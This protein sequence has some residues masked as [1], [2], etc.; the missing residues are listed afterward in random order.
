MDMVWDQ[1]RG[2]KLG[3]KRAEAP[4]KIVPGDME[5]YRMLQAIMDGRQTCAEASRVWSK[6]SSRARGYR[7]LIDKCG[8]TLTKEGIGGG[9]V[10]GILSDS[11]MA[12]A[13]SKSPSAYDTLVTAIEELGDPALES[14]RK[15]I[16]T[17]ML[18]RDLMQSDDV[19]SRYPRE[20]VLE[21]FNDIA[22]LAPT[23]VESPIALR[24]L[25]RKHVETGQLAPE[26]VS[27]IIELEKGTKGLE[28]PDIP[29]VSKEVILG[30][31]GG[32][33]APEV[34]AGPLE[35]VENK[36]TTGLSQLLSAVPG[37]KAKK[38]DDK[39]AGGKSE[40]KPKKEKDKPEFRASVQTG[41]VGG[42]SPYTFWR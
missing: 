12:R 13:M 22:S 11:A 16:R 41:S 24:A 37:P 4:A 18:L 31:A 40:S 38:K 2:A 36:L 15:S 19:L 32:S 35:R 21:A 27:T 23:V 20:A 9:F 26:D 10:S 3:E 8:R 28:G 5:P 1:S 25:L 30:T 17:R 14:E 33:K 29:D 6:K 42:E 7:Q 39:G 34:S